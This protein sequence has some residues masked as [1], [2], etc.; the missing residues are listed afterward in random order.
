MAYNNIPAVLCFND[1]ITVPPMILFYDSAWMNSPIGFI[2]A[3]D[4]VINID[5]II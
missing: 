2:L 4:F 3:N 5:C 1:D